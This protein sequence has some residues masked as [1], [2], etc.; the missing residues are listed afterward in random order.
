MTPLVVP[1]KRKVTEGVNVYFMPELEGF[2]LPFMAR[3]M[4]DKGAV[5]MGFHFAWID[6]EFK[7]GI[8]KELYGDIIFEGSDENIVVV[9]PFKELDMMPLDVDAKLIELCRELGFKTYEVGKV[10]EV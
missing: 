7:K 4:K 8:A 9:L 2:K 1:A 6:G 10:D 5:N 3:Y